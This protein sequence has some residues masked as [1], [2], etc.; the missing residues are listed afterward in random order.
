W[1]GDEAT[2]E[3]QA[4][5]DEPGASVE[6]IHGFLLDRDARA[7][8]SNA[9]AN[10]FKCIPRTRL[11]SGRGVLAFA[12]ACRMARRAYTRGKFLPLGIVPP[13]LQPLECGE[14]SS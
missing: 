13:C 6:A 4:Q 1:R 12:A 5:G 10:T 14:G 9:A 11:R 3:S 8:S 2:A 7:W